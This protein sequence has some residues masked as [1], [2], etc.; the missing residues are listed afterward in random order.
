ML[1]VVAFS[2]AELPVDVTLVAVTAVPVNETGPGVLIEVD[3]VIAPLDVTVILLSF[4]Q[5]LCFE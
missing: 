5:K 2:K 1:P 4:C 3:V